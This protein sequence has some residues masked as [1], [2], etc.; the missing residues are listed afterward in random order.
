MTPAD[1]DAE[2]PAGTASVLQTLQA[3]WLDLPGL[4]SDRVHLLTLELKRAGGAL[5]L[6][7]G[8][9]I[10]AAVL[11]STA[12]IALWVGI[13]AALLHWGLAWGW[14]FLIVLVLNLGGAFVALLRAK[15]LAHLLTLPATVRRLTV[16]PTMVATALRP[17]A[18]TRPASTHEP[19][20]GGEHV[21]AP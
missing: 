16:A 2:A 4:V 18:E 10:G 14:V 12:W 19:A 6:M 9:V 11:A 21:V 3:L 1:P 20:P 7:L 13:T 8:L 15:S 17:A 5:A